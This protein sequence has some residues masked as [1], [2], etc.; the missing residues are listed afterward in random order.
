MGTCYDPAALERNSAFSH[1]SAGD[2]FRAA[3]L[4]SP[5]KGAILSNSRPLHP[6][7]LNGL[8]LALITASE[9]PSLLIDDNLVVKAASRSFCDAY[10]R[11]DA[12]LIGM[13]L[14]AVGAGQ[15]ATPQLTTL[16]RATAAGSTEIGPYEMDAHFAD[17]GDRKLVLTARHLDYGDTET[18]LIILTI[19]DVT[20]MRLALKAKDDLLREKTILLQ[21]LQHRVA[22]SLQIVASVLL[23]SARRV[24]SE[25]TRVHLRDAHQRVMS[26][27]AVQRQLAVSSIGDVKIANYLTDLCASLGASMIRDHDQISIAVEVDDSMATADT[28]VSLGLIVTELVINALKHAFPSHRR[29]T[30]KVGYESLGDAWALT[31]GDDGVGMPTGDNVPEPGLGT[32]IIEAL[33]KQLKAKV[34]ITDLNPGTQVSIIHA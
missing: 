8:A 24:Q 21:E 29:G 9:V 16:L 30:I 17:T 13:K 28:S 1:C 19:S 2:G 7:V 4:R 34:E 15:W 12:D 14:A 27:A 23:L 3:S 22:N 11:D 5:R 18:V 20:E 33:A 6:E 25:E 10:L 32:S 31:V 26:V